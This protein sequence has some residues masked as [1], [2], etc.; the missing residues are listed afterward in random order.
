MLTEGLIIPA[1]F[2]IHRLEALAED[3]VFT[4][5]TLAAVGDIFDLAVAVHIFCAEVAY[6]EDVVSISIWVLAHVIIKLLFASTP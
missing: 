5:G 2:I 6:A 4:Y 1:D 3:S